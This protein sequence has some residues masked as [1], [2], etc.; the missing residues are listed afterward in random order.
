MARQSGH[1][2]ASG[3]SFNLVKVALKVAWSN[4]L[5]TAAFLRSD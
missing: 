4:N 3:S 1:R 2:M 5:P